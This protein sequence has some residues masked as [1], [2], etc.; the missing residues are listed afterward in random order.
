MAACDVIDHGAGCEALKND[1]A[2]VCIRPEPAPR[3]RSAKSETTRTADLTISLGLNNTHRHHALLASTRQES[4]KKPPR[5]ETRQSNGEIRTLTSHRKTTTLVARLRPDAMVAPMVLAGPINGDWFEAYVR[6]I[7]IPD[8]KVG[9]IVIMDN[10]S[11]HKCPAVKAMM[12]TAG[13]D[14]R[15]LPPY[16]PDFI[17]IENAFA[18]L[19]AFLQKPQSGPSMDCGTPS[20]ISSTSS[21]QQTASTTSPPQGT[22]QIDRSLL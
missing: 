6:Q 4:Q 3:T 21:F 14:L 18:K 22:M 9:D 1:A 7:L 19:K 13:A 5:D 11:S 10:V 20:A 15:F 2:L 12:E 8:L 17:P 16:S